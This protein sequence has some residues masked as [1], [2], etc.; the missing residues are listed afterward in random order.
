[1]KVRTLHQSYSRCFHSF[2]HR[3]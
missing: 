2:R 1:M 3:A